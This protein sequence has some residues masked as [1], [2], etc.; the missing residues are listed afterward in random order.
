M[1]PT[2]LKSLKAGNVF[3]CYFADPG[4]FIYISPTSQYPITAAYVYFTL[5]IDVCGSQFIQTYFFPYDYTLNCVSRTKLLYLASLLMY[6]EP[7]LNLIKI[8]L[9]VDRNPSLNANKHP[10]DVYWWV[11]PF[12]FPNAESNMPSLSVYWYDGEVL[13]LKLPEPLNQVW[14]TENFWNLHE[15]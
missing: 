4:T 14:S 7:Q 13:L 1:D 3:S 15:T 10:S 9:P 12:L 2:D 11:I 6:N 5:S 8:T